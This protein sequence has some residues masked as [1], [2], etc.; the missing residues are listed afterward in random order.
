MIKSLMFLLCVATTSAMAK[1][2][3]YIQGSASATQPNWIPYRQMLK[4]ANEMQSK[5]E[6]VLELKPGGNGLLALNAMNSSPKNRL[7]TISVPFLELVRQGQINESDYIPVTTQGDACWGV[8]TNM[9]ENQR[10]VESLRGIKEINLGT[11]GIGS[12]AHITALMLGEKFGFRV[13]VVL[14]KANYDALLNMAAGEN[15]NMVMERVSNYKSLLAKNSNLRLL[16]VLCNQRNPLTPEIP[17]LYEQGYNVPTIWMATV[18][19]KNMPL[20]RRDEI[21]DILNQAQ[22][23][24]GNKYLLETADLSAPM[25]RNPKIST[26]DFIKERKRIHNIMADRFDKSITESRK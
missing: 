15:I 19:N 14:Y 8:I 9:G 5:Y 17:T 20:D 25:F 18:A 12:T 26:Q 22:E 10:G 21:S 24:L 13:N 11:V 6:F 2:T 1:E 4:V 16:G 7:S 23:T 3:I